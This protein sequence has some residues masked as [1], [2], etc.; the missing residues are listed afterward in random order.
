MWDVSLGPTIY[1]W[2]TIAKYH[3]PSLDVCFVIWKV[4]P[5]EW[6]LRSLPGSM[7]DSLKMK[8]EP[9]RACD[10]SC[11]TKPNKAEWP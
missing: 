8:W 9:K 11:S 10:I 2:I 3:S 1:Q 7:K 5:A 6:P 4:Q